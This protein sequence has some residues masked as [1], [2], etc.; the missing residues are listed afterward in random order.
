M[1]KSSAAKQQ[2]EV[3]IE[4]EVTRCIRQHGRSRT[5]NEV[6]GVLIGN[7]KAGRIF[8]TAAIAARNASEGG[9]HVTFTQDAWEHIYRIKDESYPQDRIVGWYH[10]HPGFGVFLSDHDTFIQQNFFSSPDQI[11]WVY[12]PHSDEEGCFGWVDGKIARL[13]SVSVTYREGGISESL[14]LTQEFVPEFDEEEEWQLPKQETPRHQP[15]PSWLHWGIRIL[16][17][18]SVLV[19]GFALAYMFFPR[20]LYVGV[21][22]DPATGVP[23]I[24]GANP[25]HDTQGQ[26][27]T[28]PA[29]NPGNQQSPQNPSGPTEKTK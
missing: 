4:G 16:S 26:P 20:T 10:S 22:V 3:Q 21:P 1:S 11:A 8:I 14:E 12:D 7:S 24:P 19:L 2:V 17:Y 27:A 5:K 18:L 13:A 6:C 25:S 28:A 29:T 15:V 23:L 9:T